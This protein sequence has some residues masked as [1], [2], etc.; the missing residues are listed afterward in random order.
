MKHRRLFQRGAFAIAQAVALS[1]VTTGAAPALAKGMPNVAWTKLSPAA[2]PTARA[3][4]AAAY[5]PVRG[6]IVLFGGYDAST[7]LS[8]TWTFNGST[9]TKENPSTSPPP[10]AASVM[11]YDGPTQQIVM[12]GGFDGVNRLGDTWIWDGAT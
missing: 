3:A 4:C 2:S 5:D 9:W 6:K 8:E 10:R 11:A 1:L 7:Y 12:F